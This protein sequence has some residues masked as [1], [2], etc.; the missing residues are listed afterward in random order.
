MSN[1]K[2]TSSAK[3]VAKSVAKPVAKSVA[4][5][6]AAST[7]HSHSDLEL[8]MTALKEQCSN[9]CKELAELKTE[10]NDLK[11]K[12]TELDKPQDNTRDTDL[13]SLIDI[14]SAYGGPGVQN[15]IKKR[16]QKK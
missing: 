10:L 16:I 1:R 14:L 9:C 12:L 2:N 5:P 15:L 4:K 13:N 11:N 3:P 8:S 6:V 7:V